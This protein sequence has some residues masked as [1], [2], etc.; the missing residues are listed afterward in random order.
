MD[1]N[2]GRRTGSMSTC[3]TL[4]WS[5]DPLELNKVS[6]VPRERPKQQTCVK[7]ARLEVRDAWENSYSGVY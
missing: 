5:G 3:R 6:G 4:P 2:Q 7:C 1:G